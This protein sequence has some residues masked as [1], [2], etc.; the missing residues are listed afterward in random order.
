MGELLFKSGPSP[1]SATSS[2]ASV[3]RSSRRSSRSSSADPMNTLLDDDPITPPISLPPSHSGTPD[4]LPP[5]PPTRNFAGIPVLTWRDF[6]RDIN[7]FTPKYYLA[8]DLPHSLQDH[9]N[10]MSSYS[11]SLPGMRTIFETAIAENTADD[12]PDA[13][14][15]QII[16]NV[17]LEPTPPWEFY[18]TNKMWH[19]EGVPAPDVSRIVSCDCMGRC[20]PKSK[21]CACLKRQQEYTAEYTPDFVYDNRGRLKVQYVPIFEC[22]DLCG[23]S[24]E[25]R[26]RV[27]EAEFLGVFTQLSSPGGPTR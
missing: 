8:K 6:R 7:N 16:N 22:N 12:E 4:D 20:D 11:R 1:E 18:Y 21:T 9:I 23:C 27:R 25:C 15:I 26:N 24:E 17:D 13:P 19:G 2:S 5:S 14:K 10:F 3:R